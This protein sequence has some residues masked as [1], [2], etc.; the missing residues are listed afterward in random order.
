MGKK[1][2]T[3]T[4]ASESIINQPEVAE[5]ANKKQPRKRK[6]QSPKALY[7]NL[8]IIN[9]EQEDEKYLIT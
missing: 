6:S 7:R 2:P 9:E 5:L 1:K 8:M 4:Q 3:Q